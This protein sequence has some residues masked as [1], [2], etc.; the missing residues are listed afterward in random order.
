MV[1]IPIPEV[2]P[3]DEMKIERISMSKSGS[4]QRIGSKLQKVSVTT[5][6]VKVLEKTANVYFNEW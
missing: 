3:E 6:V 5:R 2:L 4:P 1:H